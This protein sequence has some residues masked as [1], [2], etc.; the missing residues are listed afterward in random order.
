MAEEKEPTAEKVQAAFTFT[1][2][3]EMFDKLISIAE[4][5]DRSMASVVRKAISFWW[6][7]DAR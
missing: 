5:D 2:P 3:V 7:Q 6:E 1:M 4:R